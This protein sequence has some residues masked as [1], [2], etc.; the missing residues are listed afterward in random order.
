[1]PERPPVA[2]EAGIASS[3]NVLDA[4]NRIDVDVLFS[5]GSRNDRILAIR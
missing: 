5:G 2:R 3:T 4:F 1:L